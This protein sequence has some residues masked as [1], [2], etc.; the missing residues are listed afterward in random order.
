MEFPLKSQRKDIEM[1]SW[2]PGCAWTSPSDVTCLLCNSVKRL[3]LPHFLGSFHSS[4]R[5]ND[6][7]FYSLTWTRCLCFGFP[8]VCPQV[9]GFVH[10]IAASDPHIPEV[11]VFFFLPHDPRSS[12]TELLIWDWGRNRQELRAQEHR[13]PICRL[14]WGLV[15]ANSCWSPWLLISLIPNIIICPTFSMFAVPTQLSLFTKPLSPSALES[16]DTP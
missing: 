1:K 11:S 15:K 2:L 12:S 3:T 10:V 13:D 9:L 6:C 8:C 14:T 5:S 16:P 7:F 4:Q